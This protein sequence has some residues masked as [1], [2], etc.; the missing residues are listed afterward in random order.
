MSTLDPTYLENVQS[1]EV[2]DKSG[3]GEV[4]TL[5]NDIPTILEE[6][7]LCMHVDHVEKNYVI[8]ILLNLNMIPHVII[9]REENMFVEIFM[10]LNYLS[11]C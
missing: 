3:F 11:L 5:V 6:C 9:M 1:Y 7:Q 4:M 10:L 2:F 8:A